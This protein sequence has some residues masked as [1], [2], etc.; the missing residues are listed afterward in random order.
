MNLTA[1]RA[2]FLLS[3][4]LLPAL[5]FAQSYTR[6]DSLAIYTLLDSADAAGE[7]NDAMKLAQQALSLSRKTG[8]ARGE[9]CCSPGYSSIATSFAR[10]YGRKKPC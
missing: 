7:M 5:R 8:M 6:A 3:G 9:G 1:L 4:L 2:I 10:S